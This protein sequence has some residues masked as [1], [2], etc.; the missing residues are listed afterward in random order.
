MVLVDPKMLD[1][2][3]QQQTVPL[4]DPLA[5][6]I[7]AID[8]TLEA[9]LNATDENIHTQA[10]EYQQ[11]LR[12]FIKLADEYR[13]RPLGKVLEIK[14]KSDVTE[15]KE[16]EEEE[17]EEEKKE[18]VK[19]KEEEEEIR[20]D[21]GSL[22]DDRVIISSIPASYRRKAE[23]VLKHIRNSSDFKI[24]ERTGE[25][26]YKG[27]AI[28]KSHITDLIN[29]VVRFRKKPESPKGLHSFVRALK[30]TNF[31]RIGIG[32]A[33]RRKLFDRFGLERTPVQKRK[34]EDGGLPRISN[35][36]QFTL[37]ETPKSTVYW[38]NYD[39]RKK[40]RNQGSGLKKIL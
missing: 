40:K 28:P 8:A 36:K 27:Q 17:E 11:A 24:D 32:N 15:R 21:H 35:G 1:H 16:E 39:A 7:K 13:D 6:K 10:L 4:Q 18:E 19:E 22:L 25:V 30:K 2:I 33:K 5:K 37:K 34:Q 26:V 20:G 9:T 31:S 12:R 29:D 3:K 23:S 14:Q 38:I